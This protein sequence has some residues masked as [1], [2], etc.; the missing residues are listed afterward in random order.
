MHFPGIDSF[1]PNATLSHAIFMLRD[2]IPADCDSIK[3]EL[4]EM[5]AAW[6]TGHLPG[7][8]TCD[9]TLNEDQMG[10]AGLLLTYISYQV[11]T[12]SRMFASQGDDAVDAAQRRLAAS[13]A[14][15]RLRAG[16]LGE[17][18]DDSIVIFR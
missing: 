4:A 12:L 1:E 15:I 2:A 9:V 16:L 8:E 17:A 5:G 10:A 13:L 3:V 7:G 6:V 14:E 18:L 11:I